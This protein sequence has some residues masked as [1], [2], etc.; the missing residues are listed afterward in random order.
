[1]VSGQQTDRDPDGGR[2]QRA[3]HADGERRARAVHDPRKHVSPEAVGT[4]HVVRIRCDLDGL[5]HRLNLSVDHLGGG[6]LRRLGETDR[7]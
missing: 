3:E 1:V 4:E 6:S 2:Q 5:S 7:R